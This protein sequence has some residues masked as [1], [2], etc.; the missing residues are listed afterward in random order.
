MTAVMFMSKL[1]VSFMVDDQ[2]AEKLLQKASEMAKANNEPSSKF[3]NRM[4]TWA[5]ENYKEGTNVPVAN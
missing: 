3:V 4:L 1:P 2:V 5:L